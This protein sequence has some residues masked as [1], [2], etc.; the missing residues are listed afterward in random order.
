L[1]DKEEERKE[2]FELD[3]KQ[4]KVVNDVS[5]MPNAELFEFFVDTY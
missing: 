5:N 3:D 4:K 2:Q 1:N